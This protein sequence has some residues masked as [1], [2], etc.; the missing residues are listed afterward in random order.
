MTEGN[1]PRMNTKATEKLLEFS[2]MYDIPVLFHN[3]I[4][5]PQIKHYPKF[6]YEMESVIKKY[7]RAKIIWA[8][9]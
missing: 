2:S 4:T 9:C 3:N 8:H 6:L 5:S 1:P 7:P